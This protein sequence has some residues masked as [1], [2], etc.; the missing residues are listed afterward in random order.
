MV[1]V[2]NRSRVPAGRR[3][4][5]RFAANGASGHAVDDL[6]PDDACE[7]PPEP[8]VT[9]EGT[10]TTVSGSKSHLPLDTT[11]KARAMRADVRRLD[12]PKDAKV[13]VR[14]RD[15]DAIYVTMTVPRGRM[16][17]VPES[18]DELRGMKGVEARAMRE[19]M[20][21]DFGGSFTT[22]QADEWLAAKRAELEANGGVASRPGDAMTRPDLRDAMEGVRRACDAYTEVTS[23]PYHDY[24]DA[25]VYVIYDIREKD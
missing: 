16:R 14:K 24:Y 7:F 3:D 4:G 2:S 22:S 1:D 17:S 9:R 13:S 21:E 8:T 10:Y 19:R 5:G 23:D 25:D 20:A 11:G 6:G 12:L 15:E 18:Y